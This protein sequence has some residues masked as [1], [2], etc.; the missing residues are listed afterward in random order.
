MT[1]R[2]PVAVLGDVVLYESDAATLGPRSWVGDL[3]IAYFFELF[4]ARLASGEGASLAAATS[5]AAAATDSPRVILLEPTVSYMAAMIGSE[6]LRE[7]L[8][9]PRT[10]GS[11]TLSDLVAEATMVLL[12]L[13][14]KSDPDAGVGGSHW[15]LL[16]FRRAEGGGAFEHYDSAGGAN[17]EHARTVAATLA[18]LVNRGGAT[19]GEVALHEMADGPQQ[20][21]LF[22]CG[23]YTIATAEVLC[24]LFAAGTLPLPGRAA[25]ALKL[26]TP[27]AIHEK[28]RALLEAVEEASRAARAGAAE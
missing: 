13:C 12:P 11:R 15:S 17:A 20:T 25:P 27:L 22:D 9:V 18:P 2:T 26:L 19:L 8:D 7:V 21:N 23:I 28:R 1:A 5:E 6:A 14:D 10:A 3:V 4:T 16:A 24:G